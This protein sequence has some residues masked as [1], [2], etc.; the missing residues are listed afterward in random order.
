MS[1]LDLSALEELLKQGEKT[2]EMTAEQYEETV[3]KPLP[4]T[5]YLKW[6]SPVA[7]KA[8][9]FGYKIQVEERVHRVLIFA[10]KDGGN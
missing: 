7:A 1:K 8:K 3:K 6:R 4:Q 9:E 2:F 10:K 5:A